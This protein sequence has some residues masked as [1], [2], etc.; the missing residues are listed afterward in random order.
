MA[1]DQDA[2]LV[3]VCKVAVTSRWVNCQLQGYVADAGAAAELEVQGRRV[4]L[5]KVVLELKLTELE[6]AC[7]ADEDGLLRQNVSLG[8]RHEQSI[9]L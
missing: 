6:L 3:Q 9:A 1:V 2:V 5:M 7:A 4:L 8:G